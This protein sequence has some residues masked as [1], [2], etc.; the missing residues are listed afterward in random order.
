MKR[1]KNIFKYLIGLVTV[2]L[3]RLIPGPQNVEP[4][5]ATMMPFSK[6]WGWLAGLLFSVASILAYDF[7]TG[8]Y[9]PWSFFTAGTYG[10]LGIL[11]GL[12]LKKRKSSIGNYVG[13]AVISTIIYDVITGFGVGMLVFKQTFMLTLLGQ[14]PYT[15]IHLTGNV[16]LAALI[17]PVLY[18]WVVDNPHLETESLLKGI[19]H[20]LAKRYH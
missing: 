3:L 12:Y 15:L 2:I 8:L 13:F 4:I 10:L 9:G 5:M 16:I 20:F 18:N 6:R 14:I 1:P 7:I 11:S 19:S 17:S